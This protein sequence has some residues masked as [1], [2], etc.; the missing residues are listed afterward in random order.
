ML[1]L[2]PDYPNPKLRP[3]KVNDLDRNRNHTST[4]N[5]DHENS[6]RHVS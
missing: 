2:H 3:S 5:T 6:E 4:V 1:G